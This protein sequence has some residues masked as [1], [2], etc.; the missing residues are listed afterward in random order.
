MFFEFILPSLS[1]TDLV[2][3]RA[4]PFL[5]V[6]LEFVHTVFHPT[7]FSGYVSA[8]FLRLLYIQWWSSTE[9][10][11]HA[12]AICEYHK[13]LFY[14]IYKIA[15]EGIERV[16]SPARFCRV[17]TSSLAVRNCHEVSTQ[18]ASVLPQGERG[19]IPSC[20]PPLTLAAL[21]QAQQQLSPS[22]A[23]V[24]QRDFVLQASLNT[25]IFKWE[26][27]LLWQERRES[28]EV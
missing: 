27:V 8:F 19:N 28:W 22:L 23:T 20:P 6:G 21:T 18:R 10:P 5:H 16:K 2:L 4:C 15:E 13:H 1:R 11:T 26:Y 14:S 24:L 17:N 9:Q 3:L 7:F 25:Y 12:N